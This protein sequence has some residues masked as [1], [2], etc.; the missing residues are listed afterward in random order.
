[1][2][3]SCFNLRKQALLEQTGFT[4]KRKTKMF[5]G[6]RDKLLNHLSSNTAMMGE[7]DLVTAIT[8]IWELIMPTNTS[9]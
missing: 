7:D 9:Q 3:L 6:F 5:E 4:E 8:L 1:M 2:I